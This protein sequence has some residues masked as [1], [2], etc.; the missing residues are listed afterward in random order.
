M[1]FL[2]PLPFIPR[3]QNE[4]MHFALCDP[5]VASDD[6]KPF[7]PDESPAASV[8]KRYEP[9]FSDSPGR[10]TM[11]KMSDVEFGKLFDDIKKKKVERPSNSKYM[12]A[13][14]I[15]ARLEIFARTALD[16]QLWPLIVLIAHKMGF[17]FG[18]PE[19]HLYSMFQFMEQ[20]NSILLLLLF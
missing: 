17:F 7:D 5:V 16:G 6:G 12:W 1:E 13:G 2:A 8:R 3:Q 20:V 14:N 4:F 18:R 11:R 15:D 19:E 10:S 9:N